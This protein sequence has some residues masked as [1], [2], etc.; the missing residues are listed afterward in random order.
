VT[1]LDRASASGQ[2][3]QASKWR[4]P[5]SEERWV[6]L[7]RYLDWWQ[8]ETDHSG[9]RGPFHS[10]ALTGADICWLAEQ[11][12]RDEFGSVPNLHLASANLFGAHLAS[13]NLSEAHLQGAN[14]VRA[15]LEGADLY[16]AHL[17]GAISAAWLTHTSVGS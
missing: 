8:A 17:E 16:Q 13:A 2:K 11:S 10:M 1:N 15:S 9:R 12:G 4:E 7:Q 5:I 6:E 14:L 3:G